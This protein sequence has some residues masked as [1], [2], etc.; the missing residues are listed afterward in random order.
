MHD[1]DKQHGLQACQLEVLKGYLRPCQARFGW[2]Q[3]LGFRVQAEP[4]SKFW[5]CLIFELDLD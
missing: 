3:A 2:V 1:I 4:G 5:D